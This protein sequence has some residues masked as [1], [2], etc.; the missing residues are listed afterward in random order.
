MTRPI[1]PLLYS[2][3][4]TIGLCFLLLSAI[5]AWPAATPAPEKLLPDDTLVLVTAPDFAKLRETWKKMP[6]SQLW[7]DQAMKPFKDHFLSKW[8]EEVVKPL[9]RELGIKFDDYT[10]LLQGQVTLAVLQNGWQGG[11]DPEPALVLLIDSRDKKDLLKQN[12]TQFR[13][14]WVDSGKTLRT[15]KIHDAEF[16]VFSLS[17][18]DVPKSISKLLPQSSQETPEE[19]DEPQTKK[20]LKKIEWA[21]GQVD[22]LLVAGSSTKALEKVVARVSGGTVPP[23]SELASYQA[24]YTGL[25]RDALF[26]S[27]INAK[28]IIDVF[29]RKAGEKKQNPDS[30]NPMDVSPEKVANAVGLGSL[31][32]ISASF[33]N[34]DQGA[35]LLASLGVPE[36]TR[37]GLFKILVGEPKEVLPP[38]FVP[39]D[40]V[41]F[42]RWRIDGQKTWAALERMVNDISPQW[43]TGINFLLE[44]ANTAAKEKD[45]GFDVKRNLI[46]NLGDDLITYDK[47]AKGNSVKELA[48]PPSLFLV[49]SPKPEDLAI[50]LKSLL[51]LIGQQT[52]TQPEEREFL[53]R[54]IYSI[55]LRSLGLP[56]PGATGAG[57]PVTLRYAA[58]GGY[59]ALSTDASILEEFLR[60][61]ETQAKSLKET[62]GLNDAAQRVLGPGS[63]LFGFENQTETI[64]GWFEL[65][66]KDSGSAT[67]SPVAAVLSGVNP[68]FKDWVDLSLLPPFDQVSKYFYF[69]V[70]GAGATVDGLTFKMFSPTP[71]GAKAAAASKP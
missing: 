30:Q 12:L 60:S 58:S 5:A 22:S 57:G 17:T 49:G 45:P 25:F 46:G 47:A 16:V 48:S 65:L 15:E 3:R 43:M 61:S 39:A 28:S 32:T 42:Q 18:N 41:K 33:Q 7:N 31:R 11:D 34:S 24:S 53:G 63:S 36:A 26:Y 37:Q 44:T 6:Q 1:H 50:A 2:S 67:N 38:A 64:R 52:G 4:T 66:R 68:N 8:N 20:Q 70:Y 59:L 62:P 29:V 55:P 21:L 23:L 9:E 19:G 35:L 13:K 27:W 10:A 54:K 51:V 56:M 71:P 14:K 40:A 69:S